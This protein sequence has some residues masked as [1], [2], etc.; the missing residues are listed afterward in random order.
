MA[1]E[2]LDLAR[3]A[4]STDIRMMECATAAL[5]QLGD[6]CPEQQ[7]DLRPVYDMATRRRPAAQPDQK[8]TLAT[9]FNRTHSQTQEGGVV[10]EE[11]RIEYVADRTNTFGK[12][13]LGP[14]WNVPGAMTINT[15]PFRRRIIIRCRPFQQQPRFG[16]Y[17]LQRRSL[18]DTDSS[19]PGSGA[20]AE[21]YPGKNPAAG[22]SHSAPELPAELPEVAGSCPQSLGK[23]L[24]IAS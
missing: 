17:P 6:R 12:A 16:H 2:W 4:D 11:Y 7:S 21:V 5:A 1:V 13:F 3:Y 15:I 24:R 9:F 22:R 14:P 20:E 23:Y 8:S 18:A 19:Q 10:D